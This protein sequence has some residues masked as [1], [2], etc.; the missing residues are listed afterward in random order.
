MTYWQFLSEISND[1]DY[2]I[3][4]HSKYQAFDVSDVDHP[5]FGGVSFKRKL[6]LLPCPLQLNCVD[7]RIC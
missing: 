5:N 2:I 1:H 4:H 7:L 3:G 6:H